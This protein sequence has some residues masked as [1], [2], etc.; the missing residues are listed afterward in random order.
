MQFY[1]FNLLKDH[2][3]HFEKNKIVSSAIINTARRALEPFEM[4]LQNAITALEKKQNIKAKWKK[5][6]TENIAEL[7]LIGKL[8]EVPKQTFVQI[9]ESIANDIKKETVIR[10]SVNDHR[11]VSIDGSNIVFD[12]LPEQDEMLFWNKK[13]IEYKIIPASKPKGTI[14]REEQNRYI[15]YSENGQKPNDN[16]SEI[17]NRKLASFIDFENLRFENGQI[18]NATRNNDLNITLSDINDFNKI[19]ICDKLKFKIENTRKNSKDAFW[20]QLLELDD[21]ADDDIPGFSTLKYFFDDGIDIEDDQKNKYQ[22]GFG[23]ESENRIV[24]KKKNDKGYWQFCIPPEDSILTVKVNTYQLR[25]QIEAISTLMRMPVGE[26]Y[27]LIKLFEN[28]EKTK[29]PSP[30]KE[31]IEEWF[32]ITDE[33]RSGTKEQR[34]FIH[35]AI[36]TPDFAI[37][38]GPPGSGKTTVILELICQL[39]KRGKRVLLCGSTHVAIDNVLERLKEKRNNISLL[40]QFHILP[41]RI[42]DEHRISDN[43]KEFQINNL[44][45]ENSIDESLLL[46]ISNLVCGTTIGILQHPKFKQRKGTLKKDEKEGRLMYSSSE[47]IVPEFDYLIIDESSKTTFQEFL[48]P[49]LYA[50]KWILAGDI[51]QLSP[52]TDREEIVSNIEQLSVDGKP[53]SNELQQ[54]VFYLQKIKDCLREK[55]NKFV[56][57]VSLETLNY[58]LLE[59]FNGRNEDYKNRGICVVVG[60]NQEEAKNKLLVK[61]KIKNVSK[62][63]LGAYDMIIIEDHLLEKNLHLI[64]ESHAVLRSKK[65]QESEH[66]FVHNVYQQ[67]H[68]FH[69]KEKGR[70]FENSFEI[71]ESVNTYFAEKSWAEEIA[72]RIDREH[73]IRL[74]NNSKLK[75][76]YGKAIEELIPKSLNKEKI[77]EKINTIASMAFP[78]ILESLVKGISG[79]KLKFESTI[80]EGF[81]QCDISHRKTTLRYQHRMHPDIS[82]F[83][84]EQFYQS[85]NALLD[86]EKPKHIKNLRQWDFDKYPYR[87][88]WID[89]KGN[90]FEGKNHD[91]V[92]VMIKELKEFVEFAKNNVQPEGKEWSVACLTFYRGQETLLREELQKLTENENGYSNFN[93]TSGKY[94]INIKLHT[95]D[96]FQG[97]EADVVFLSMVQTNRD[98]FLDNPN[99]LNV[100]ITRAKFQLVV[101]GSY[102]YYTKKSNSEDLKALAKNTHRL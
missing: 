36:N 25:K 86:L 99:R 98:G 82:K 57:P 23:I 20:I 8:F 42:G 27:K 68:S 47:P 45:E 26:H 74:T 58:I 80:S 96:K 35:Q 10:G 73:Q 5:I 7:R 90:A 28:R 59:L 17:Q 54:A 91:E 9:D 41:V 81:N 75:G 92:K 22:L 2:E 102:D 79:R 69:Y 77:E 3:L 71:V 16:A 100:A 21:N 87:N 37:L 38:E 29:W 72:W 31:R 97:Q 48:V 44:I 18:L 12:I 53:I 83:P 67:K 65:W 84:R 46:D 60:N 51:M 70:E 1:Y 11:V 63:E 95:V 30:L 89:V 13:T 50:K 33:T 76:S 39:V 43:V 62:I 14:I 55:H 24:L 52:F 61:R 64:P 88:I 66:A 32:V 4:Y 49:A 78:S 15:V 101:I 40:E 34:Q 93:I 19:V 6:K 56:L 94:R 85:E